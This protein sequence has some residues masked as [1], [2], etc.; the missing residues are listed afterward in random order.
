L[1]FS[2]PTPLAAVGRSMLVSLVRRPI[3]YYLHCSTAV[4]HAYA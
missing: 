1:Y 4:S 3:A 2:S